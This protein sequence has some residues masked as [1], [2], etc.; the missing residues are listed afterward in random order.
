[1]KR[2]LMSLVFVSILMFG[3]IAA[4]HQDTQ[5]ALK[6]GLITGL[7]ATYLPASFDVKSFRLSIAG[8][9]IVIP[10]SLR[11]IL[12][13]DMRADP[14]DDSPPQIEIIPSTF[15]FSASWRREVL[16]GD[17]SP[18]MVIMITPKGTDRLFHL[19]IDMDNLRF[20]SATL[21][22]NNL[23]SV[24]IDLGDKADTQKKKTGEQVVAP[25]GP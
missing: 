1:M 11:L 18:Y 24:P 10:E 2:I 6:D 21:L 14:F 5:L 12:M 19:N 20:I 9:K 23:G 3:G 7:S 8:K 4:G 15:V 22:I 25:N 13:R 17:Q 16:Q